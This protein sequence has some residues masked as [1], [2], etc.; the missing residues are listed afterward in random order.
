M[1]E[2]YDFE[3]ETVDIFHQVDGVHEKVDNYVAVRNAETEDL[4]A[5]VTKKYKPVLNKILV[6]ALKKALSDKGYTYK[7][8]YWLEKGKRR[9]FMEF[10]LENA[11]TLRGD[12]IFPHLLLINS[13]D[14]S[15]AETLHVTAKH[16]NMPYLVIGPKGK[17]HIKRRHVGSAEEDFGTMLQNAMDVFA[18]AIVEMETWA[19]IGVSMDQAQAMI[20]SIDMKKTAKAT[21]L[22][23]YA[24]A[25]DQVLLT[26][27]EETEKSIWTGANKKDQSGLI[28][29]VQWGFDQ[30]RRAAIREKII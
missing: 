11:E 13:Y 19:G 7:D 26:L 9:F 15:Y 10:L 17:T 4:L 3:V 23:N 2:E 6:D 24:A 18:E 22:E 21:T 27:V 29:Y 25:S 20:E 1:K 12:E 8:E 28:E 16:P 14:A 5:I 30:L